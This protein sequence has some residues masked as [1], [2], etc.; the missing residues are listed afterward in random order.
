M[1]YSATGASPGA[2]RLQRAALN[3]DDWKITTVPGTYVDAMPLGDGRLMT[4]R[5]DGTFTYIADP[6]P[7][8]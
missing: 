2:R 1:D 7:D 3:V 8:R 5:K 6:V 4:M